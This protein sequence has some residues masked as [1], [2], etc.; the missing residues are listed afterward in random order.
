MQLNEA[1]SWAAGD[2]TGGKVNEVL[3]P[4]A[5]GLRHKRMS[6]GNSETRWLGERVAGLKMM[7]ETDL[8]YQFLNVAVKRNF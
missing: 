7:S 1:G 4:R 3:P 6:P 2:P 5:K 8:N